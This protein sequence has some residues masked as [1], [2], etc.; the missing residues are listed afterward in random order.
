MVETKDGLKPDP[1]FCFD[2]QY[3]KNFKPK[4]MDGKVETFY[5]WPISKVMEIVARGFDFKFNYNLV[6]I[7]FLLRYNLIPKNHPDFD[8]LAKGLR[9]SL[10][11][12]KT[13]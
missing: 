13:S 5:R 12:V 11:P 6:I 4:N 10:N 3:P 1:K 7:D 9:N 2:L 8:R